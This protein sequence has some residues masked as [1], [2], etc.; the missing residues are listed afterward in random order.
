[1]LYLVF[2]SMESPLGVGVHQA[3]MH[4]HALERILVHVNFNLSGT[5]FGFVA[6]PW[7]VEHMSPRG[8]DLWDGKG[9]K[10]KGKKRKGKRKG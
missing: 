9:K 4:R 1:M 8:V 7:V 6:T 2:P 3:A 5:P 10:R